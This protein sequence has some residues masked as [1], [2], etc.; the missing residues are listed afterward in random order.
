M[1]AFDFLAAVLACVA[2]LR[3]WFRSSLLVGWRAG[4]EVKADRSAV[5][6]LVTCPFC[7][8]HHLAFLVVGGFAAAC[9]WAPAAAAAVRPFLYA[10]AAAPLIYW[11]FAATESLDP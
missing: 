8:G 5:S 11:A 3:V 4:H 6:R 1:T 2:A 9:E 7:L 10:A